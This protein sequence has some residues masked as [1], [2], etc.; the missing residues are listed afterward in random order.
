LVL[1][2]ERVIVVT[3]MI[4]RASP[5]DIDLS[6]LWCV[7]Q[8]ALERRVRQT[9]TPTVADRIKLLFPPQID[10]KFHRMVALLDSE[11]I[12]EV[13]VVDVG[14]RRKQRRKANRSSC[15]RW[16]IAAR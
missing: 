5:G 11:H 13:I 4:N 3:E 10:A 12:R 15:G 16:I 7:L 9:A 6:C 1:D 2:K 8:K 14:E